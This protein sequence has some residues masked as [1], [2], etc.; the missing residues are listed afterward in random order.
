MKGKFN[1]LL[2]AILFIFTM[3][4]C[5]EEELPPQQSVDEVVNEVTEGLADQDNLSLFIEAFE[6][7]DVNSEDI[8]QGIT[9]FAPLNEALEG[10]DGS[11][12]SGGRLSATDSTGSELTSE[13]L[14]DHIVKG[15]I[16]T[17]D[18][19][20][21]DTLTTLNGNPLKVLVDGENISVNGVLLSDKDIASTTNYVVHTVTQVLSNTTPQAETGTIEVTVWNGDKWTPE[22]PQGEKEAGVTVSLYNSQEDYAQGIPVDTAQT[23]ADGIATFMDLD[24]T[25]VYYIVAEKGDI[26]NI[27]YKSPQAENG[28]Y[29]GM[30]PDGLFQ[31]QEEV[32]SHA[33]QSDARPGNFRWKDINADGVINTSDR[34]AVPHREIQAVTGQTSQ[35][36][37]IIGYNDNFNMGPILTRE[38]ALH[39]LENSYRSIDILQKNFV[40]LDGTLSDDADCMTNNYWCEIDNFAFN[41]SHPVITYLW[42]YGYKTVG[43]L[44]KIL[45]DV[46]DLTFAEKEE[47]IAQAKGLRAYFYLQLLTYF[48][49]IPLQTGLELEESAMRSP[50][51]EVYDYLITGLNEAAQ[52]LP[53]AWSSDKSYQL[54]SNAIKVLLARAALWKKDYATVATY[55]NEVLQSGS[56]Q[57]MA[58]D[59]TVF[60]D[61]GNAEIIWDFTFDSNAEFSNYFY[62]RSFCPDVRLAEVYLMNAEAQFNMGNTQAGLNSLN[63]LRER[64]GMAPA[65]SSGELSATWKAAMS[66]EGNRF[67][68]LVRWGQAY[69]VLAP[70][71]YNDPIHALLPVPQVFIDNYYNLI[72]NPGY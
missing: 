18:L 38:V 29:T 11:S 5:E 50:A 55:T 31:S 36:D 54:N 35:I 15:I 52:V 48:G 14:K 45:Q 10:Y 12:S 72:Q 9:V 68:N 26:S 40:M 19:N 24:P 27:F 51:S 13:E 47:V 17:S 70:K 63:I 32:D 1:Y 60:A 33:G 56:Y 25:K 69:E 8:E 42:Q 4:A 37:V 6:G 16:K 44:N 22:M 30:H 3:A 34:A 66:R 46:P 59:A 58:D 23:G 28:V 65:T 43:K 64:M 67:A 71:G 41:S 49:D 53:A 20:H 62:G 39:I 57:L 7:L 2:A 61:A 21:G